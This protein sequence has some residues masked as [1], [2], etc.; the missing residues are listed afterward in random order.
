[1][2]DTV[3]P[4]INEHGFIPEA[5]IP[6]CRNCGG[7]VFGNVRGDGNFLHGLYDEQNYALRRWM[8]M[9]VDSNRTVAIVEVGAGFNTP[10]V[11]RFPMESFARQLG[12]RGRFIRINPS[13]VEVP[14]DLKK[15]IS[16][17]EG[18]Q[19]LKDI[20]GQV[21]TPGR[22]KDSDIDAGYGSSISTRDDCPVRAN[23]PVYSKFRPLRLEYLPEPIRRTKGLI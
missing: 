5:L 9:N 1:M 3:V 23:S 10:T 2:L 12:E 11:T 13:D 17:D 15:A 20:Y 7:D 19:V 18:W 4:H 22:A 8:K 14:S 21:I 16:I 6:K